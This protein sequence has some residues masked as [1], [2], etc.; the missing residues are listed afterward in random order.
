MDDLQERRRLTR[1]RTLKGGRIVFNNGRSVIDCV[2]RNMTPQGAL[3]TLPSILGVPKTFDLYIDG[4]VIP[5]P[6]RVVMRDAT[7][8]GVTWD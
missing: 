5:R 1:K 3:L 2:V 6:A 4:E 7:S 8:L